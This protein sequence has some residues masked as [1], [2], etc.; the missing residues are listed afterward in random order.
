MNELFVASSTLLPADKLVDGS[1]T[2]LQIVDVEGRVVVEVPAVLRMHSR[3]GEVVKTYF[4]F[5]DRVALQG[6]DT[7]EAFRYCWVEYRLDEL[8]DGSVQPAAL[9]AMAG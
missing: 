1:S 4:A 7:S 8:Q 2:S 5:E 9:H 3:K 6:S